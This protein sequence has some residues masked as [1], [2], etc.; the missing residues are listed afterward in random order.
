MVV[1]LG[2][3]EFLLILSHTDSAGAEALALRLGRAGFGVRPDGEPVTISIGV[4]GRQHEFAR[5]LPQ[6]IEIAERRMYAAKRRGKNRL[7]S[8][9]DRVLPWERGGAERNR[10]DGPGDT[11]L[12]TG[13]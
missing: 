5:D 3:E 2:G 6:L 13:S 9:G 1:R 4:V 12:K 8:C 10:P 11:M 7:V